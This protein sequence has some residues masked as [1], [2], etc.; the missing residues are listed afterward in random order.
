V[1]DKLSLMDKAKKVDKF[2]NVNNVDCASQLNEAKREIKVLN[3]Q[4][5]QLVTS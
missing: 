5:T 1:L 2:T 4:L 3:Y